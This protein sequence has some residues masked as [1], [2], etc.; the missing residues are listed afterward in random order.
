MTT[1]DFLSTIAANAFGETFLQEI[2]NVY[3]RNAEADGVDTLEADYLDAKNFLTAVLSPEKLAKLAAYENTCKSIWDFG[4]RFGFEAGLFCG[5]KQFFTLNKD[6][7]GGFYIHV[8]NEIATMPN[9]A[10]H[11]E[12]YQNIQQRN[13]LLDELI[14][15]TIAEQLITVDCAW[16]QRERSASI[17]GFYCGYLGA[18]QIIDN[19]ERSHGG[20]HSMQ[21]QL[22][23][24]EQ[25][26]GYC[27]GAK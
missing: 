9:M 11:P 15:D 25:Y 21:N 22:L 18:M 20:S 6:E 3:Q 19:V 4:A 1:R 26:F 14:N 17:H 7:D 24:M 27:K 10:C 13:A 23:A 5:F 8:D 12:N 2:G 16:S